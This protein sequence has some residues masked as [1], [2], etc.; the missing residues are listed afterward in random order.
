MDFQTIIDYIKVCLLEKYADFNGRAR[1]AEYW[2]F[3]LFNG[4]I[5]TI[6][7]MLGKNGGFFSIL[8]TLFSLAVL[9]PGLAV[10]W[11][12]MHDIGKKGTWGLIALI[13]I[14]GWI[15]VIV[16]CCQDS[17]PGENEFGP[18]PKE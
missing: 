6:L 5:S 2:S 17:Q 10:L 7:S 14:V 11:R 8:A 16:W 18:N 12:R 3:A 1:R 9:V 15:L 4:V 13:P